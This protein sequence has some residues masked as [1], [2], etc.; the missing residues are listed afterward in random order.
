MVLGS[1]V[2]SVARESQRSAAFETLND[3]TNDP[4]TI[5]PQ[6]RRQQFDNFSPIQ[7]QEKPIINRRLPIRPRTTTPRLAQP[8]QPVQP[9]QFATFNQKHQ[10][11]M[12]QHQ[13]AVENVLRLQQQQERQTNFQQQQQQPNF[14]TPVSAPVQQ[15]PSNL[16]QEA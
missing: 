14:F 7:Q 9:A 15:A 13:L 10:D 2:Q 4:R 16:V 1:L 6:V 8:I 11:E 5:L 12:R 3:R